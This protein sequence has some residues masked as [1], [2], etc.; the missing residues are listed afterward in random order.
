[1]VRVDDDGLTIRVP[2]RK[3]ILFDKADFR[4]GWTYWTLF[5]IDCGHLRWRCP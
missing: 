4:R 1:M 3:I 2:L 5:L